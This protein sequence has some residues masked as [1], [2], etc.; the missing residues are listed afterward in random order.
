[1]ELQVMALVD[2]D[3]QCDEFIV[4]NITASFILLNSSEF[5]NT[6]IMMKF[7]ATHSKCNKEELFRR[8]QPAK[9]LLKYNLYNF[10]SELFPF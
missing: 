4:I 9:S 1:M 2:M 10:F 6:G 5:R 8:T 3:Y 7:Q